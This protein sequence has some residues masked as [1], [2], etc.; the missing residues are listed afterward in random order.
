[1]IFLILALSLILRLVNLGQSL[2][3]DEAISVNIARSL[4]FKS[5]ILYF[6]P[7][8]FHPPLFYLVLKSWVWLFGAS[9]ISARL[10]SVI[11]GL[12]TVYVIYLL[13]KKLYEEKIALIAA[14]LLATAPLHIYYSQEARMYMLAAFLVSLSAYFFMSV[15]E[16]DKIVNWVGFILSTAL[17]LYS[18]YIPYLMLPLYF[19]YL[20]LI[21]RKVTRSTLIGF[22]PAFLLIF[23]LIAPWLLV[24]PS[25]LKLG[26]SVSAAS[27]AW[28]KVVGS[29]HIKDLGI[30]F[31]KFTIGRISNDNNLIYAILF[32]PVGL[33]VT[34][35]FLFSLFR[36]SLKRFFLWMWLFFPVLS[37]FLI[38]Q[39]IPVFTYFRFIFVL[40]P[41]YLIW[42][43]AINTVNIQKLVRLL[44]FGA[45]AVNLVPTAIYYV[46]PKFQR[47]NWRDATDYVR[48][49][50]TQNSVILFE[51]A[52]TFA[53]FDYYSKGY[54][55]AYGALNSF[56]ANPDEVN[57][58]V[59][60][61]TQGVNKVFLFQYLSGIT[62]PQGLV[63]KE[64]IMSGFGNTGTKNFDGVGFVY[65]FTR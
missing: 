64:L 48:Q 33:F 28:A 19:V 8:D 21:R 62:D 35:L 14:T 13:G 56:A 3:L 29:S 27:P 55:K 22:I 1:M 5:I 34:V 7:S 54:L 59:K 12:A 52:N 42:A 60:R 50:S 53:P 39:F 31:V 20:F 45:L 2:W 58:N 57:S 32:A 51:S 30:A 26:L 25:Q 9:E 38:S 37:A 16:K 49:K 44:L 65:E 15:L 24:L 40:V 47:E 41:F 4:P 63:Y 46:N 61:L 11:F 36:M 43:S 6:S 10:P 17:M 23:I 18:D